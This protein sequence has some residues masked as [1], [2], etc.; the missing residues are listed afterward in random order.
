MS[1]FLLSGSYREIVLVLFLIM[2]SAELLALY[3]HH[4]SFTWV[5]ILLIV[6]FPLLIYFS[7]LF[8]SPYVNIHILEYKGN[9]IGVNLIGFLIPVLVSGKVILGGRVP[10]RDAVAIVSLV[11][12]VTYLYTY[13]DPNIGI[14]TYFFAIPPILSAAIVF[15]LR[16]HGRELNPALLSYVGATLG[17]IIGADLLHIPMLLSYRWQTP[18]LVVIGGGGV[19]DSIFLAG[20]VAVGADLLIRKTKF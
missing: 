17:V 3:L 4:S 11:S 2:I 12:F 20:L 9:T 6:S 5:E 7:G 10:W 19:A 18:V 16:L 1:P 8:G 15:M 13:F 14:V